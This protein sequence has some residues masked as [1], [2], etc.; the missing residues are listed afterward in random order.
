MPN[1][2]NH[3]PSY[4]RT[5]GEI[6]EALPSQANSVSTQSGNTKSSSITGAGAVMLVP[7]GKPPSETVLGKLRNIAQSVSKGSLMDDREL[8]MSLAQHF[9]SRL[10]C[11]KKYER[12][13]GADHGYDEKVSGNDVTDENF[14][15]AEMKLFDAIDFLNKPASPQFVAGKLAQL[16][17][18]MARASESQNDIEIVIATYAEHIRQYPQDIVAYVIDR[19]IHT[20]KWFPLISELCAEMEGI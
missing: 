20:R 3:Q 4:P 19:C 10:V 16:R 5:L 18:V 6:L 12:V 14:A 17:A 15:D 2:V 9:G 8:E 11:K 13:Y 1:E 7:I